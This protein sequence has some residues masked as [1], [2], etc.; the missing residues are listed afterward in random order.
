MSSSADPSST[1]DP[2]P[3]GARRRWRILL[4]RAIGMAALGLAAAGV[5]LPLLPTTPFLLVAVWAFARGA[6]E[7]GARLY[8]H[9]KFGPFLRDWDERQAIPV[10]GKVASIVGM[11]LAFAMVFYRTENLVARVVSGAVMGAVA[12]YIL[13]RPS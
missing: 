4:Y 11:S 8:S 7:L 13:T 10:S 6:P 5:A 3:G 12:I 9:P 2:K 1:P